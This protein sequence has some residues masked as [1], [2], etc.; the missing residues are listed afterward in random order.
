MKITIFQW[1]HFTIKQ[2][3][4]RIVILLM[5]LSLGGQVCAYALY[6]R[7]ISRKVIRQTQTLE[8]LLSRAVIIH[9]KIEQFITTNHIHTLEDYILWL[10]NNTQYRPDENGDQWSTPEETLDRKYGDCEDLAFLN[11]EVLKKLGYQPRVLAFGHNGEAHV[12]TVIKKD[13]VIQ[14]LDNNTF[15]KTKAVN[16]E[17]VALFLAQKYQSNFLIELSLKPKN[18]NILYL[19]NKK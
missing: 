6:S 10:K 3:I 15:H 9:S 11:Y 4:A 5:I 14:I 18:I 13:G 19:T 2:K 7:D 1:P 8:Q 17:D 16:L 12:F